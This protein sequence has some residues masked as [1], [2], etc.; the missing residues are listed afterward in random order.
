MSK[1]LI[2]S[3]PHRLGKEEALR[4][5]KSGLASAH[6]NFGQFYSVQEEEDRRPPAVSRQRAR[7]GGERQH[8]CRRGPRAARNGPPG[9]LA[10]IAETLQPLI[11]KEGTL[12]LENKRGTDS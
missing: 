10:K 6:A 2:V 12:M 3:I 11:R 9:L 1:P 5:L 7:T 4:R 8:R